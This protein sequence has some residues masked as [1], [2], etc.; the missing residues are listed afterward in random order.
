MHTGAALADR[1]VYGASSAYLSGKQQLLQSHSTTAAAA[2]QLFV[3]LWQLAAR[4][5]AQLYYFNPL[6]LRCRRKGTWG[7]RWKTAFLSVL[8]FIC[9]SHTPFFNLLLPDVQ[10][11]QPDELRQL[12]PELS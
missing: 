10:T 2:L 8:Y 1:S 7:V 4:Q 5:G 11:D 6:R 3:L 9:K 12:P